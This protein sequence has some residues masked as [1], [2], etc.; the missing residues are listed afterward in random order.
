MLPLVMEFTRAQTTPR[1]RIIAEALG[2]DTLGLDDDTAAGRAITG[3]RELIATLGVPH[4]ISGT[5]GNREAFG[6][7]ADHVMG[8]PSVAACPRPVTRHDV[9]DLLRA[10]W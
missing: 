4:T 9:L 1:L 2:A 10:A 6:T 8:D 3:V 5:G 7:I